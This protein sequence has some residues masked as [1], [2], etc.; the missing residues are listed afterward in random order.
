MP[1]ADVDRII[2]ANF[3]FLYF[4]VYFV[5]TSEH[6]RS[7]RQSF[8]YGGQVK[9]LPTHGSHRRAQIDRIDVEL[10]QCRQAKQTG[11]IV[12]RH[13]CRETCN[14]VANLRSV[15]DVET[16]NGERDAAFGKFADQV[17]AMAVDAGEYGEVAPTAALDL[18]C[19]LDLPGEIGSLDFFISPGNDFDQRRGIGFSSLLG[20]VVAQRF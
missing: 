6:R 3:I 20:F 18:A 7:V 16:L 11:S 14:Y 1:D 17:L 12:R 2:R 9:L 10:R 4:A 5:D 13:S 8:E 15:E 19:L